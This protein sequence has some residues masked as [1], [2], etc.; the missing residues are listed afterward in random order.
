MIRIVLNRCQ[1]AAAGMIFMACMAG[2]ECCRPYN[3]VWV[4]ARLAIRFLCS[5][6]A[7][8]CVEK[9][10]FT[11]VPRSPRPCANLHDGRGGAKANYFNMHFNPCVGA[12]SKG[13]KKCRSCIARA[14]RSSSKTRKKRATGIASYTTTANWS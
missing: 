3:V 10:N 2:G 6:F 13:K 5:H 11:T 12:S 9:E 4:G 14:P 1:S 8:L 7:W